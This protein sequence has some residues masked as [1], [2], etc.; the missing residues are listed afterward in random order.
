MPS[1]LPGFEYDVFISYRQ[2]DNRSGWVT[3]FVRALQEELAAT[4]KDPLSVYFDSNP[5]DGLLETHLVDK[6][7]E[8]KLKCLLFIPI[9]SQTYCDPN[10]FAWQHE[11]CV[12]NKFSKTDKFGRD[13]RLSNGNVASRILPVKIHDLDSADEKVLETE[14]NGVLRAIDFIY[15]E[16]G[17]NRPLKPIDSKSENQNKTN[18]GNQLNKT[19]NAIKEIFFSIQHPQS[20]QTA[21]I[22]A[23]RPTHANRKSIVVL[24]FV[25]MSNDPEQE[26]FSDGLTEEVITDLSG[27]KDLLVIS[28]SSAMTF[29]GS[30]LRISEIAGE[31]RVR[32]ALEGSVRRSGNNIRITVQ[33]IDS[34][35][36]SH[37]WAEKYNGS[38]EDIFAIQEKVSRAVVVALQLKLTPQ[39]DQDINRHDFD[40]VQAY[41]YYLRAKAEMFKWNPASNQTAL[42]LLQKGL[43]L[44]GP[45]TILHGGM[46]YAY[47]SFANLGVDAQIN[48]KKAEE[49]VEITFK[50]DPNS[51]EAYLVDG[52]LNLT[53]YGNPSGAI[54]GFKNVLLARPYDTHALTWLSLVMAVCGKMDSAGVLADRLVSV[55]PL[56]PISRAMHTVIRYYSGQFEGASSVIHEIYQSEPEN[57]FWKYFTVAC[58][59]NEG[60]NVE[61]LKFI[62]AHVSGDDAIVKLTIGFKHVFSGEP[63]HIIQIIKDPILYEAARI[64][65]QYSQF[66]S[67]LCAWAGLENEA[68][69]W[70]ENAINRGFLNSLFISD[71]DPAYRRMRANK[72]FQ[73]LVERAKNDSAQIESL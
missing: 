26:Y 52:L 15:K 41:E 19:A 7:L 11:F 57:S 9:I 18:Y 38:L 58:Y 46:A 69:F 49:Y 45:N 43:S 66:V 4:L 5:H 54:R 33:L 1:I 50:K 60:K 12:F 48:F 31:V 73:E 2:N 59:V 63:S 70:L 25:N 37:L 47:W 55:D 8:G 62:D 71:G 17:V 36:D 24:P 72:K 28:R 16:P 35:N 40:N 68:L 23:Q 61:A 32:Y 14:L 20:K 34:Q 21:G 65:G 3:E 6:S 10:G 39:E 53:V 29:K 13:I 67:S 56:S 44:I 51:P 64:D 22:N 42:T 27:L 30:K